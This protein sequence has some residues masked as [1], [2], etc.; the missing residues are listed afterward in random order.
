M[1]ITEELHVRV[2]ERDNYQCIVKGCGSN[3]N[4]ESNHIIPKT[5]GGATTYDNLETLCRKCHYCVDHNEPSLIFW[6]PEE[7]EEWLRLYSE[8][9]NRA[10]EFKEVKEKHKTC[11]W[12]CYEYLIQKGKKDELNNEND[13]RLEEL[14]MNRDNSF[15]QH[16]AMFDAGYPKNNGEG[17]QLAFEIYV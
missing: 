16:K 10:N 8:Q 5:Q 11:R 4:L 3:E 2:R 9:K 7:Y 17:E 14:R 6:S 12:V 1:N 15:Y 13:K